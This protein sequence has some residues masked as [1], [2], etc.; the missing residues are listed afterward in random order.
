MAVPSQVVE[1]LDA[2]YPQ[3]RENPNFYL[4]QGDAPAIAHLVALIDAIPDE[5]ITLRGQALAEYGESVSR[6]RYTVDRWRRNTGDTL[7]GLPQEPTRNV[8][9]YIRT[10]L[11]SLPDDAVT[12][13]VVDLPFISDNDFRESLRL[14]IQ[15]ATRSI[16]VRDW[17]GCTV[18]AGSVVE[19][20]LLWAV[21]EEASQR[22]GDV[23]TAIDAL[24]S[25]GT[26]KRPDADFNRWDLHQLTEVAA[27]LDVIGRE[28]ADHCR[29]TRSFRNLIHPGRATRL[30]Q[31]CTR[32]TALSALATVE[33]VAD[34]LS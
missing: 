28:T 12:T 1:F 4:S 33:H 16:E 34:D 25:N 8:L 6:V 29:L 21:S 2:R 20:L 7:Q 11:A 24:V 5:L 26:V 23:T 14:D 19:A 27:E 30:G 10:H 18:V 9:S 13:P 22:A 3:L 31:R 32:G 15:S 17:K